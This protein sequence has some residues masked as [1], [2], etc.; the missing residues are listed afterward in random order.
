MVLFQTDGATI[1]SAIQTLG[2]SVVVALALLYFAYKVWIYMAKQVEKKDDVI[3]AQIAYQ[4]T[5]GAQISATQEKILDTFDTHTGLMRELK[6][7][8]ENNNR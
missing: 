1:L 6:S 8:I 2:F 7:A 3:N 4:Q 5:F